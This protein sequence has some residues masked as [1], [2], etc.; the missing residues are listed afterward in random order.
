M[1]ISLYSIIS[2]LQ[3]LNIPI[4]QHPNNSKSQYCNIPISPFT[5]VSISQCLNIPISQYL[6]I[7]IF[8]YLRVKGKGCDNCFQ[9][10]N[11]IECGPNFGSSS[12][13]LGCNSVFLFQAQKS[14]KSLKLAQNFTLARSDFWYSPLV[15]LKSE[16]EKTKEE[17]CTSHH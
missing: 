17:M 1:P 3:N 12:N 4:S 6:I 7:S 2:I 10:L 11:I 14:Q 9:N 15:A 5:N 16:R 13:I 8:H